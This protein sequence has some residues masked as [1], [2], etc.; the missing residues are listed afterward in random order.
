LVGYALVHLLL[1]FVAIR[2]VLGASSGSATGEGALAQLAGD[3]LGRVTL[4]V[5]AVGFAVLVAWQLTAA[6]V[7]YRDRH[8]WSRYLMRAGAACRLVVYGYLAYSC[9]GFALTSGS[10]ASGSPES[11]TAKL[12]AL[13][14][15]PWLVAAVGATTGGV[16]IGL[17]VFGW[18]TGFLDQL[19]DEARNHDRRVPIV[20][21]GRAGYVA[22][23][24]AL[25]VVG[26]LLVWAAWSHDPRKSGGLDGALHEL[27]GGRLG[28]AA[29]IAVALGIG[30][31]GLY[32]LARARHLNRD[33]L[34]S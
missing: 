16:G 33:A 2:L 25:I 5:M 21:V 14:Y 31:F 7:G 1:A 15:G 22:K 19:D 20:L 11:G 3:L 4:G 27:L 28:S 9:A 24:L 34:T 17:A 10:A 13:P 26:V 8:G 12:M 30:C 29:V 6:A 32:L 23:G 18:Q